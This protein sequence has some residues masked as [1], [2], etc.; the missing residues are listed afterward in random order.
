MPRRL[1][2]FLL[3]LFCAG[4]FSGERGYYIFVGGDDV[5]KRFFKEYR[6]NNTTYVKNEYCWSTRSASGI[7]LVYINLIP[8][9]IDQELISNV[10]R[11]DSSA[12]N[13]IQYILSTYHDDEIDHGFDGM[14]YVDRMKSGLKIHLIPLV[15]EPT[16]VYSEK[17]MMA[18]DFN[19][20]SILSGVDKYFNP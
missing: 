4:C 1:F 18:F 6:E 13:R 17:N 19:I 9:G 11:G 10:V 7:S 20:C 2:C 14:L 12:V 8:N 15:G 16:S 3:F 5:G